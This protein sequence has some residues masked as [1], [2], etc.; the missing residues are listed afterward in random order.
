MWRHGDVLIALVDAIP[1]DAELLPGTILARGEAT[2]H[3][4]RV[5]ENGTAEI[6]RNST[7]MFLRVVAPSAQ[8]VHEE[9]NPI[10]LSQG[11]YRFW[12]QREYSPREIRRIVD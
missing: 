2:G 12:F 6:W 3:A 4:H 11:S 9:H 8:I 7:H 10:T 1:A 5:R